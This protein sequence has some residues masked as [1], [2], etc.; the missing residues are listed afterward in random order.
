[1]GARD[2]ERQRPNVF[3]MRILGAEVRPVSDGSATLKDA[4]NAAFREWASTSDDTHLA[5]G[6]AA[7]PIPSRRWCAV[8]KR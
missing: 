1:M 2:V 3:R 7:G 6:T 8:T 5:V 4:M